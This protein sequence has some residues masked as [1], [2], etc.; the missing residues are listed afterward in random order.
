[1]NM[2]SLSAEIS[3]R[4]KNF[5]A[6]WKS[7]LDT[8][9]KNLESNGSVFEASY[10]RI[11]TLQAWKTELLESRISPDSMS[12][13]LEAQND[14]LMSH[15]LSQFGSWRSALQSLRSCAENVL[16]CLYYM[17]HPVE[18]MQWGMG[19]HKIGFRELHGYISAHPNIKSNI[20]NE[21]LEII[22]N[23]YSTLSQAVHASS[24]NFRMSEDASKIRLWKSDK[25]HVGAWSTRERQVIRSLNLL[26]L[27]LFSND[28]TGA[29]RLN[30]RRVVGLCLTAT[31]RT[32]IRTELKINLP[33]S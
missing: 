26:L 22:K 32:N 2:A 14:A 6:S 5:S 33:A 27:E 23:E 21:G 9:R 15:V 18:L 28:L 12:F 4:Y 8:E 7:T 30:L 13:Y 24:A 1:M 31:Q 3:G 25:K 16:N 17:D 29:A 10:Q 20:A 19:K 11:A